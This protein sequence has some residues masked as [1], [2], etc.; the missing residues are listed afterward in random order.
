MSGNRP[1]GRHT[2][3][4]LVVEDDAE[5]RDVTIE[6]LKAFGYEVYEAGNGPEALTVLDRDIPIDIVF[7]DVVMPKGI[8]GVALAR[9]ARRRRPGV[10]VLLTSGYAREL[11]LSGQALDENLEFI[12]KP[13][14]MSELADRLR[15]IMPARRLDQ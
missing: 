8:D 13:Y 11:L 5:R 7:T 2:R 9:E 10:R 15:A 1:T 6:V 14:H 12:S 4:V 3:S